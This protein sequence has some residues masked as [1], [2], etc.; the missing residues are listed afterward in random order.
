MIPRSLGGRLTASFLCKSC[1]DDLGHRIEALARTDP[2]VTLAIRDFEAIHPEQARRVAE[3]M[4]LI[5]H[6]EGGSSKA[7]RQGGDI[8]IRSH[9]LPDGSLV[10]PTDDA[11]ETVRR[12]L[13]K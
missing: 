12:M 7:R 2:A 13:E 11:R 5:V 4:S 8:R 3:G 6:S 9:Q 10:Q 1:N